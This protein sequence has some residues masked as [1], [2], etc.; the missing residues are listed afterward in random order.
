MHGRGQSN[1]GARGAA[2]VGAVGRRRRLEYLRQ[3]QH[4]HVVSAKQ[5]A[6]SARRFQHGRSVLLVRYLSGG[7]RGPKRQGV[8]DQGSR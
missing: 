3:I 7:A 2:D 1:R 6:R 4:Q 8:R 5:H